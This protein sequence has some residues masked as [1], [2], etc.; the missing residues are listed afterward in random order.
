MIFQTFPS[1][2]LLTAMLLLVLTVLQAATLVLAPFPESHP[3]SFLNPVI[4]PW[5]HQLD[6]E[7]QVKIYALWET[8]EPSLI[9][10]GTETL[11]PL[12]NEITRIYFF[13]PKL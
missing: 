10:F 3:Y 8:T 5:W 2:R 7:T 11:F 9:A 12:R 1:S 13:Q 4:D 6:Q